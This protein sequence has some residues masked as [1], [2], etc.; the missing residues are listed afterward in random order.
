MIRSHTST[1]MKGLTKTIY[2]SIDPPDWSIQCKCSSCGGIKTYRQMLKSHVKKYVV[3][4]L[5]ME[6]ANAFTRKRWNRTDKTDR[7]ILRA[8][9]R[10]T[11][12]SAKKKGVPFAFTFDEFLECWEKSDKRCPILGTDFD[13]QNGRRGSDQSRLPS[14]DKIIPALGYVPGNVRFISMRANR[15]KQDITV[16]QAERLLAYLR[17]EL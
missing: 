12:F 16:D 8:R 10:A 3:H 7:Q 6:C 15:M 5:C 2:S 1:S 11:E 9:Y 13:F 4:S 17:G 14:L